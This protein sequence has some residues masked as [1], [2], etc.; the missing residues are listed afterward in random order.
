MTTATLGF[1]IH[2]ERAK[3]AAVDLDKLAGSSEKAE[4]A[5][6]KLRVSSGAADK[7]ISAL[8]AASTKAAGGNTAFAQASEMAAE[9]QR[10]ATAATTAMTAAMDR[11]AKASKMAAYQSRMLAVQMGDVAQSLALGIPVQ[12]VLLQQGFQIQGLYGGIGDTLRGVA[13]AARSAAA[14]LGRVAVTNPVVTAG[15]AAMSVGLVNVTRDLKAAGHES[16]TFG[17]VA[18]AAWQVAASGIRNALQ[19]AISAIAPWVGA[20]WDWISEK[21]KWLG[22]LIINSFRAAAYDIKFLWNNLPVIV[23]SA[24]IEA[25]NATIRGIEMMIN[26]ATELLNKFV[27]KANSVLPQSM[28]MGEVGQ[29]S[30]GQ[31]DNPLRGQ[32]DAALAERNAAIEGIMSSDPLG[33]FGSAVKDQAIANATAAMEGLST[34]TG[35]ARDAWAGLRGEVDPV[36][37][38]FRQQFEDT[39]PFAE[40]ERS[41]MMVNDLLDRGKISMQ[42]W[43]NAAIR[44]K[45]QVAEAVLG[46]AGQLNGAL[47]TMFGD[48]KA[49]ALA[50]AV[51]STA[52][53]IA[54][55]ISIYGPT[56]WGMAAAGVAAA[57]GAAQIATIQRTNKGSTSKPSVSGSGGGGI[58]ATNSNTPTQPTQAV[59]ITLQG[60]SYSRESVEGLI[61]QLNE[62][63]A[64]GHK[65][66][67]TRG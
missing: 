4:K 54:K 62:A 19:P 30:F 67:I 15:I 42:E 13:G 18:M 50:D 2:S 60:D 21:T 27:R 26:G 25:A 43:S 20:A 14:S 1:E 33:D 64:D 28:Q 49:F 55:A 22:N 23:G 40:Y 57:T 38:A 39:S 16:I 10:R 9:A 47:A 56:P 45:A 17:N 46:L 59:N 35:Q 24:A 51:I 58:S 48:S 61:E 36:L 7:A 12:Q 41:M 31:F 3:Q 34:A 66:V 29:V 63:A 53:A 44:A 65:I 52:Q 5:S 8:R 11:Q 6:E 32:A 37:A